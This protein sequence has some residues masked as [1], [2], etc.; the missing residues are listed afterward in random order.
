[1]LSLTK[2]LSGKEEVILLDFTTIEDPVTHT[3]EKA[4]SIYHLIGDAGILNFPDP[5]AKKMIGRSITVMNDS[6]SDMTVGANPPV[7]P[8]N[9]E[10][11]T[12]DS[13]T[14]Y[15]FKSRGDRWIC[16][17]KNA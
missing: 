1:M 3:I 16:V 4:N 10:L 14:V 2:I 17:S 13:R 5:E 6:V 8:R 15:V 9:A 7:D 12:I 11:G